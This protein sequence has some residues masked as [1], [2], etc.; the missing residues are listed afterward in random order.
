MGNSINLTSYLIPVSLILLGVVVIVIAW[1]ARRSTRQ[2]VVHYPSQQLEFE[3][4]ERMA[5][6]AS[7][8]VVN[9][10]VVVHYPSQNRQLVHV[11]LSVTPPGGKP[12]FASNNWEVDETAMAYL[13]AGA[14]L[15]VKIDTQNP[16]IIYPN[17]GW[18]SYS[19]NR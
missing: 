7:A 2:K 12:Y 4:R 6:L 3:Q 11:Q 14:E 10:R 18:A 16:N 8:T 1:A 15:A 9:A 19:L 5:A 13:Q 17:T